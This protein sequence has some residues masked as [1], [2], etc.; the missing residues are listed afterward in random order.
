MGIQHLA[1]GGGIEQAVLLELA[2]DL[3]Q[4]VADLAQQAD[5]HGLVVDEG[6]AAA[7][8]AELAAQQQIAFDL[9]AL[10][11]EKGARPDGAGAGRTRR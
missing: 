4:P 11:G 8:G 1:M 2:D 6:A 10:L 7:V 3:H 5:A 9:E